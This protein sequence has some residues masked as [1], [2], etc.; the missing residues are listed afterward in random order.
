M[1][2][3]SSSK[4]TSGIMIST[5]GCLAGVG[6]D[7]GGRLDDGPHL[8]GVDLGPLDAQ[9]A[10]AGAQHG[11]GLGQGLDLGRQ[12]LLSAISAAGALVSCRRSS[13]TT[14]SV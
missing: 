7:V 8:H 9:T 3:S 13:S 6:Q 10:A 12:R 5:C 1:S 14:T 4:P 11:V 2:L